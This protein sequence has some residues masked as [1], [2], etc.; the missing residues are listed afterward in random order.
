MGSMVWLIPVQSIFAK[1]R[2]RLLA[3]L[4]G[5]VFLFAIGK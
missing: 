1:L 2:E 3:I 4:S 5:A